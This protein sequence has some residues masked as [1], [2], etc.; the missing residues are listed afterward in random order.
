MNE[1]DM[2]KAAAH[3]DR[4]RLTAE[5]RA[6]RELLRSSNYSPSSKLARALQII[7]RLCPPPDPTPLSDPELLYLLQKADESEDPDMILSAADKV[8]IALLQ[9]TSKPA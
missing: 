1:K 6:W 9:R 3:E 7:D 8:R 5:E 4:F 2:D